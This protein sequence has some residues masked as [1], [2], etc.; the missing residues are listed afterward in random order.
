MIPFRRKRPIHKRTY[1]HYPSSRFAC[2]L[3]GLG[4]GY[5]EWRAIDLQADPAWIALAQLCPKA[6]SIDLARLTMD[7]DFY[8]IGITK[9]VD[10]IFLPNHGSS[11]A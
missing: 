6:Q 1:R 11:P 10:T 7:L 8:V 2:R 9:L 3:R 4:Y 5:E